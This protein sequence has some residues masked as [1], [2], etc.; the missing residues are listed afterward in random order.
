VGPNWY[1]R[2]SSSVGKLFGI[3]KFRH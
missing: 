1:W 3:S 2:K